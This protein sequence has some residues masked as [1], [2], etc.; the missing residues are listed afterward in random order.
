LNPLTVIGT[1]VSTKSF[2]SAANGVPLLTNEAGLAGLC[3]QETNDECARV[4]NVASTPE[5]YGR[6]IYN[7]MTD[8]GSWTQSS[9]A[10]RRHAHKTFV[11]DVLDQESTLKGL[12]RA[13]T[14]K[15]CSEKLQNAD[16]GH[17]PGW[18]KFKSQW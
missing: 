8:E 5:E 18:L 2:L 17:R 16:Y 4:F 3:L 1:G 15:R 9:L 14:N 10:V 7:L 11:P 13:L 6:V 12:L